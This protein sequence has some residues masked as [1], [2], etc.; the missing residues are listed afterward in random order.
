MAARVFV[1][2]NVLLPFYFPELEPFAVCNA[3]LQQLKQES[4][5]LCVSGQVIREFYVRATNP[6]T[7]EKVTAADRDLP[8]ETDPL[9]RIIESLPQ[10]FDIVDQPHAVHEMLPQLL[11]EYQVRGTLTHDTNILA[12]MLVHGF[13]TICS[14]DSDFERFSNRV[15]ILRPQ[16]G[17]ALQGADPA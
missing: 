16:L 5:E 15:T 10:F 4:A 14:L 8:L 3:F 7:F 1:D 13:D 9:L 11:R 12:T 6:R 17:H 2:T